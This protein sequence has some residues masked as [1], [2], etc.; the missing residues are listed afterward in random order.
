MPKPN[1]RRRAAIAIALASLPA[2]LPAQPVIGVHGAAVI[3]VDGQRFRDANGNGSLEPYEDWRLAVG[4]RIADLVGRMT[5]EEKAGMLVH[6]RLSVTEDGAVPPID[7]AAADDPD[8]EQVTFHEPEPSVF[9]VQRHIRTML[10]NGVAP[11]REFAEWSNRMQAL[12]ESTRLGIPILFSSDPRHGAALGAH[13][14]G[15]QYFSRWPSREGQFGLA[16]SRN[17][18]NSL[19]L[20]RVTAEEY[21]AVGLHMNLGP[22][23]DLTTEPRWRRNAGSFSE[24]ADL[25]SEQV[26]A[27]VRGAQGPTLGPKSIL[28]MIKHWPGSGPHL[29]GQGRQLVYPGNNFAYHL[30]P[31]RAAFGAGAMTV[32]GYYSGT[33]FDD[34]LAV[35]YSH[36]IM[37]E[38]LRGEFGFDGVITTDWGVISRVGPLREDVVN[39]GIP[40]RY[41]MALEAGVDQFGGESDPAPLI[42]LVRSGEI[43]EGRIDESVARI[44]RWHFGLGL[45]ENPYVDAAAAEGI[46]GS[47]RNQALGYQAQLESVVLLANDGTLPIRNDRPRI[48]TEGMDADAVGRYGEVVDEPGNADIALLRVDASVLYAPGQ[49]ADSTDIRLPEAVVGRIDTVL[50]TGV[51]TVVGIN[52]GSTLVVLPRDLSTRVGALLMLFDVQDEAVLDVLFGRFPPVGRLPFELPSSMQAVDAQ[53]EDV[54]FDSPDPLFEFGFGLTY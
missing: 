12:A 1:R 52:I 33:P 4:E 42:G 17:A 51:P 19:E 35:N 54:P 34:G 10:N 18:V 53:L 32:M 23:V 24:D 8:A 14:K 36:Y 49:S 31:F 26:A 3:E 21:R 46:V 47:L 11:P 27:Y 28:A 38:L 7:P 48:Y 41:R 16:A 25:T 37:T 15:Q 40:E 9:V 29:D 22:Q 2:T 45:F 5:L 30:Q 13:V 20:G 6:P 39:L 50:A 43:S 44:L